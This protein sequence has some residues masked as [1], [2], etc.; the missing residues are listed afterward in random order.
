MANG[1]MEC[2]IVIVLNIGET[3]IPPTWMLRVVHAQD[4]H[5]N[6]INDLCFAIRLGVE[7]SGF[8]ELGVL[9]MILVNMM[10]YC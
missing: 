4:V 1:A 10:M 7:R 8:S 6:I 5:N 2:P 9:P 3:V